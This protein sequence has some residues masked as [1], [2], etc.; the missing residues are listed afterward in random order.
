ME[1]HALFPFGVY[2]PFYHRLCVL[3][4]CCKCY[5]AWNRDSEI[6][7]RPL[8]E[9]VSPDK[10][11]K[12]FRDEFKEDAIKVRSKITSKMEFDQYIFDEKFSKRRRVH[13]LFTNGSIAAAIVDIRNVGRLNNVNIDKLY[14]SKNA[15]LEKGYRK[16]YAYIYINEKTDVS[17]ELI[18]IARKQ[19]IDIVRK[20]E[21]SPDQLAKQIDTELLK[22]EGIQANDTIYDDT[23]SAPGKCMHV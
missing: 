2:K 13:V 23:D 21:I 10:I 16:V 18:N 17:P 3:V 11:G 1:I 5:S 4:Y 8:Y 19:N 14:L 7:R 22:A 6:E 15:L 20:G 9:N 12:Q